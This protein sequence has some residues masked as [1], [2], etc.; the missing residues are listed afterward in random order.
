MKPL[1]RLILLQLSGAAAA[2]A[3]PI[4]TDLVA[5][6]NFEQTGTNGLVNKAPGP[7]GFNGA[8][9]TTP[10]NGAGAGF[11]GNAAFPGAVATATTNRSTLLVGNALNVVKAAT[12]TGQFTVSTLTSRGPGLNSDFGTLGTRFTISSWFYLAPDAD[13][14]SLSADAQR[15]FVF[16]SNLDGTTS[17]TVFDVSFGTTAAN[18][19]YASFVGG[20]SS[21]ANN[22]TLAAGGW[23]HVVH[24][25]DV[26]GAN[27]VVTVYINGALRGTGSAATST[28]DFRGINFGSN[29]SGTSRVF[30]GLIDEVAV[31]RR[32]L[33]ASEVTEVYNLGIANTPLAATIPLT[34]SSANAAQGTYTG[35]TNGNY[36]TGSTISLTAVPA[37]G[38]VFAA[39]T[40]DFAGQPASFTTTAGSTALTSTATF[41]P[42][43]ADS[44]ND[45]LTNFQEII[46]HGTSPSNADTDGD[47]I[48]DGV[49]VNTTGTSPT[50]SDTSLITF[51]QENLSPATAGAIAFSPV[52]L[53]RNPTSGE[54]QLS[55]NF[56]G[57]ADQTTWSTIPLNDPSVSITPS[58]TGWDLVL[59]APSNTVNSYILKGS[60]P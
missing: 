55:F 5:Y 51:V 52:T 46:T 34:V 38:Y 58:G 35:S 7:L 13:N 41:G 2:L 16:E 25:F 19:I 33:S 27:T 36:L 43:T 17:T 40:G 9:V 59:P 29:R 57:S 22:A 56:L 11:S 39:W 47:Q 21:A 6:Y 37:S 54:I 15:Q 1:P 4:H 48:P 28:V 10:A 12:P 31:W 50:Q 49:E 53:E 23:H 45:G 44:D 8:Y 30:D 18:T 32:A 3:A 26:S 14:T 20:I 24:S 42:D 60:K